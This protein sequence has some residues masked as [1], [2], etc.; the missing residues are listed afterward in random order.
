MPKPRI[1]YYNDGR[2]SHTY[3]YEPPMRPEEYVSMVDEIV[4]TPIE[5]LMLCLG[6]GRTM[7]HDTKV[8]ELMG[9]NVDK[10][11]E[12]VFRRSYQ[13]AKHLIDEGNDPLRI[14]CE[15]AHEKGISLYATLIVQRGGADHVPVRC[16]DFRKNNPQLEIG[17]AGDLEPGYPGF[18]AMD[19]KHREARDERFAIVEEVMT[20]YPVD[21]F[22]LYLN[23]KGVLT[24]PAAVT[25]YF[26][27]PKEIDSGRKIMT[28]WI[29][30][31]HEEVKRSGSERELV[32]RIPLSLDECL[33]AGL[34]PE[35]WIRQGIVDVLVGEGDLGQMTDFRPL[36]DAT[37]GTE[38]RVHASVNNGV[39]SDRLGGAPISAMRATACNYW[40][41]GVEGLYLMGW[42]GEW[43][44]ADAF[45]G[46]LRE[47]PHPDIMAAKDKFYFVPTS[48][49]ESTPL[50]TKME[51][52]R[53]AAVKLTIT[54]D[55]PRWGKEDRVHEVLI[56][57]RVLGHTELD[58]LS[59]RLN[60]KELPENTHRRINELYKQRVPHDRIMGGYWHIFRLGP[61]H[62]P[63]TGENTLEATLLERDPDLVERFCTLRDVEL[64]IKY[65]MGRSFHRGDGVGIGDV[66]PDL[67]PHD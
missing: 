8:G 30:R 28:D 16:S 50:P 57:M 14:V 51:L 43:P 63:V 34:D 36:V 59:F 58:R 38:T 17:A 11:D 54:D 32:V 9:H 15:R 22:E 40:S 2:H 66:D 18:E 33:A 60:G 23:A 12:T 3:R 26:F 25:P 21:G 64:E 7:L 46:K 5:A 20:E 61:E 39:G 19:F 45:Y 6:E 29:G 27:H 56:R 37:K 35:E 24:S 49:R 65:L 41:Q 31:V 10:W 52:D 48:E 53:P 42:H 1:M 13:N 47:L 67:G 44:Y 55:L 4:S 62:W